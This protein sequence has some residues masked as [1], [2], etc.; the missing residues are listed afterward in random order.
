MTYSVF[1]M[2]FTVAGVRSVFTEMTSLGQ[3]EVTCLFSDDSSD[4]SHL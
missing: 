4:T 1:S 2:G 3:E